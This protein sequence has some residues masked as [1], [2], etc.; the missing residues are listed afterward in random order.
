MDLH[1]LSE[2]FSGRKFGEIVL[3]HYKSLKEDALVPALVANIES[4]PTSAKPLAEAWIDEISAFGTDPSFWQ[5]DAGQTFNL[6]CNAAR[7]RLDSAGVPIS[8]DDVFAM[9]QIILLN[10]VYGLH[11]E[12]QSK[13][14]IQQSLGM[15]FLRRMFG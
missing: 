6:I 1:G 13:S 8:N 12:P 4:L 3:H 15:G 14:F 7:N 10:F 11:K 2:Q 5:S 9:F